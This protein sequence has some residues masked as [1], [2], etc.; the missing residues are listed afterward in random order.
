MSHHDPHH[1]GEVMR[2]TNP[3]CRPANAIFVSFAPPRESKDFFDAAQ[4]SACSFID[5]AVG[6]W[7][8][9]ASSLIVS[10]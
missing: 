9:P 6:A 8:L 5:G 1:L 7:T 4:S 2:Q 10:T 3:A